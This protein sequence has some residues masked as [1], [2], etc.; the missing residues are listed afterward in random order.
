MEKLKGADC[1]T[2]CGMLC[3]AKNRKK[4]VFT[5]NF[6]LRVG[7]S[8][9]VYPAV[10]SGMGLIGAIVFAVIAA[11]FYFCSR[12]KK[13]CICIPMLRDLHKKER[14]RF[15]ARAYWWTSLIAVIIMIIIGLMD[16][17]C[18]KSDPRDCHNYDWGV[19]TAKTMAENAESLE[20]LA[21]IPKNIENLVDMMRGILCV[22]AIVTIL[23][24]LYVVKMKNI[25]VVFCCKSYKKQAGIATSDSESD[26]QEKAKKGGST[27]F[28][29]TNVVSNH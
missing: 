16:P 10:E 29:Q 11:I 22:V 28:V 3:K 14:K 7:V 27:E 23:L 15:F 9:W 24:D 26:D 21:D 19:E 5:L 25:K 18:T 20:D 13:M 4:G 12:S 17:K 2:V 8:V 1:C 6:L